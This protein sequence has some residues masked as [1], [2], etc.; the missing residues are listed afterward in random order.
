MPDHLNGVFFYDDTSAYSA[1]HIIV[2]VAIYSKFEEE[3]SE[4]RKM[5]KSNKEIKISYFSMAL[6]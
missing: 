1:Y 3:T 2:C 5:T 6:R 4:K